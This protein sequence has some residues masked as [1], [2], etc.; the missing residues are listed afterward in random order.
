MSL[1][2]IKGA[3]GLA[4]LDDKD[5][6]T[7]DRKSNVYISAFITGY[8]RLKLYHEALEPLNEKVLYFDTDSVIYVSYM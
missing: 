6:Y 7:E 1:K 3:C 4:S 5:A 2:L 8:A